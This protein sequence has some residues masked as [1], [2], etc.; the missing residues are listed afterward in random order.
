MLQDSV[1]KMLAALPLVKEL[2][3]NADLLSKELARIL[4]PSALKE[5]MGNNF[6]QNACTRLPKTQCFD[7]KRLKN[8]HII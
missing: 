3:C 6:V 8:M 1:P 5:T 7:Y 4:V 2:Y